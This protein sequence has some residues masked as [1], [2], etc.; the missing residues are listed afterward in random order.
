MWLWLRYTDGS[1]MTLR[2]DGGAHQVS[3]LDRGAGVALSFRL[4]NHMIL[5]A[6]SAPRC[7]PESPCRRR[8]A[9]REVSVPL[10]GATSVAN[11]PV[12][13]ANLA[14]A[15]AISAHHLQTASNTVWDIKCANTRCDCDSKQSGNMGFELKVAPSERSSVRTAHRVPSVTCQG[16]SAHV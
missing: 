9:L 10:V 6:R 2:E 4:M 16:S 7:R 8:G 13:R 1:A 14:P 11:S 15:V 3:K 12:D 5:F